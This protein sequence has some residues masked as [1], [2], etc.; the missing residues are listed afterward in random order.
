M[1]ELNGNLVATI[2]FVAAGVFVAFTQEFLLITGDTVSLAMCVALA[3]LFALPLT[4]LALVFRHKMTVE[5]P[6]EW[7]QVSLWCKAT[8]PTEDATEPPK[9][10]LYN[11]IGIQSLLIHNL[12]GASGCA[13]AMTL[14]A[15]F[16]L[17]LAYEFTED[18]YTIKYD[19]MVMLILAPL[20]EQFT[21]S[22]AYSGGQK[23]AAALTAMA[24]FVALAA[25]PCVDTFE[26]ITWD[27]YEDPEIVPV[28]H[29]LFT[30]TMVFGIILRWAVTVFMVMFLHG[31]RTT[32]VESGSS[33]INRIRVYAMSLL[34][35]VCTGLTA[36]VVSFFREE[37]EDSVYSEMWSSSSV[38]Y[39]LTFGVLLWL[40]TLPTVLA[41]HGLYFVCVVTSM[42]IALYSIIV[43]V[44][45]MY[46]APVYGVGLMAA[47]VCQWYFWRKKGRARDKLGRIPA[48]P[49]EE[50]EEVS[51]DFVNTNPAEEE[52]QPHSD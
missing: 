45:T 13:V 38:P 10:W 28:P 24:M 8:D 14:A 44:C 31:M 12:L 9:D 35:F 40:L 4:F 25:C 2:A 22:I 41:V 15:L 52:E 17:P 7:Y 30:K 6:T 32:L 39:L 42:Q 48:P 21:A 3:A 47:L 1:C 37:I 5:G 11:H 51:L 26:H 19:I 34:F 29:Q 20:T 43:V 33:A 16:V 18:K 27:E 36:G 46:S 23:L 49:I 50:F